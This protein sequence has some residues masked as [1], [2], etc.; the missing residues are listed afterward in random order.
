M[1]RG[2]SGIGVAIDVGGT[3]TRLGFNFPD[4]S[5]QHE[6][7]SKQVSSKA[8]LEDFIQEMVGTMGEIPSKCVVDF[9]GPV[10]EHREVQLTNWS[11]NPTIRLSDLISYG[12]P[13]GATLMV[14]DMEAAGYGVESLAENQSVPSCRCLSLYEPPGG[15]SE[16]SG[17]NKVI[18]AP[19][20]GLGTIGVLSNKK[21]GTVEPI[22]SE[23]QHS[24]LAALDEEHHELLDWYRS[25]RKYTPSWEDFVS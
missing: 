11:G 21:K 3:N 20:T 6:I 13:D 18:L 9:A 16:E 7:I 19:D 10:W 22:P 5:C 23:V 1:A 14:N 15:V 8:E 4:N 2:E 17:G 24:P 25:Y 12:L